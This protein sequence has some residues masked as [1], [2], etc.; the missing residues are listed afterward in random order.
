MEIHHE[1]KKTPLDISQQHSWLLDTEHSL[2]FREEIVDNYYRYQCWQYARRTI[3]SSLL[4]CN[5]LTFYSLKVTH[6]NLNR[7]FLAFTAL[8]ILF[9]SLSTFFEKMIVQ[10][11]NG[12]NGPR[13]K[14]G[15]CVTVMLITVAVFAFLLDRYHVTEELQRVPSCRPENT[16]NFKP[17]YPG[18]T[19][20]PQDPKVR[21]HIGSVC[22][23]IN[24]MAPEG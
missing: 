17:S 15:E 9:W 2:S 22:M 4:K 16:I 14:Y 13:Y 18:W 3:P 8:I 7:D 21:C 1:L 24:N 11:Q 19:P 23:S 12:G 6:Y 20:K 10:H 5:L